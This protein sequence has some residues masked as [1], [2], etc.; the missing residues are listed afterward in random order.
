M[1][2][3]GVGLAI[4]GESEELPRSGYGGDDFVDL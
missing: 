1:N 2:D 3:D 4:H